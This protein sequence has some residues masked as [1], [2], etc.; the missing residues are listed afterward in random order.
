[1]I[2]EN[3]NVFLIA[4]SDITKVMKVFPNTKENPYVL[5]ELI[6]TGSDESCSEKVILDDFSGVWIRMQ[7]MGHVGEQFRC[8]FMIG[9][10]DGMPSL[11]AHRVKEILDENEIK[12][13]LNGGE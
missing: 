5:E 11:Y 6:S 8:V 3:G 13:Q 12:Y 4:P 9:Y 7:P 1:M 2:L 10:D